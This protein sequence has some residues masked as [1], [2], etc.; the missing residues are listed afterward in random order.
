MKTADRDKP[1]EV[2]RLTRNTPEQAQARCILYEQIG[3]KGFKAPAKNCQPDNAPYGP[4]P[5]FI[6][7]PLYLCRT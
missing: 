7:E 2:T 6:Q 4:L 3:A 5:L 1:E